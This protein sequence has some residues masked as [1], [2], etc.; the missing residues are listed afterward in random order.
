ME[1]EAILEELK[2][3]R[4]DI[5]KLKKEFSENKDVKEG[6]FEK[7]E[8]YSTE[9]DTLYEE[10]KQIEKEN[11]LDLINKDL[12]ERRVELDSFKTKLDELN[13]K[14]EVMKKS[15][16]ARPK[17]PAVKTLSVEKIKKEIK[18]LDLKLQTQVLSLDKESE[19][20]KEISDL[21][22][23]IAMYNT[24]SEDSEENSEIK[25]I[26]KEL[27]YFRRKYAATEKKI[28][29]LYKQIRLISKEKKRR[30]KRIDE[31]RD[32]KKKSF[33]EFRSTKK[34]YSEVGKTL[35]DL[36]KKESDL[37]EEIGESPTQKKRFMD[38][39]MKI[40]RKE[41]EDKLMNKGV[42]TTED[43]LAFQNKR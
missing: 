8:S 7:G 1:K 26:K 12:E 37:M 20:L 33:E 39:E 9:I 18:K 21:K 35:K 34:N 11:N 29:S 24:D 40:K 3:V 43:L 36:F 22:E 23:K 30:Y 41:V 25:E 28:R 31:L 13:S 15:D 19:L 10:I 6:H 14:F 4:A 32:L 17:K 27:N 16:V 2:K 5:R 38:K 42:L